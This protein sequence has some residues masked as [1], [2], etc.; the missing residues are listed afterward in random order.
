VWHLYLV[1]VVIGV[2]SVFFDVAYQS[3]IPILVPDGEVGLA[4]SRLET[5]AQLATTGGP[6]LGGLLMKIISAPLVMLTD[7]VGYAVSLLFFLR[8]QDDETAS[9]ARDPRASSA[10]WSDIGEGLSYVWRQPA[11][12]RITACT[13][14]S[15]LCATVVA[16]VMP[17][18]VLRELALGPFTLGLVLTCGSAGGAVGAWLTPRLR[19]RL[20]ASQLVVGANVL[21]ILFYLSNPLAAILGPDHPLLATC[22]LC[23]GQSGTMAAML[24]YNITQV[25]LRQILC[26]RPLLGRMNA[27]IRFIVGGVIPLSAMLSGWLAGHLGIATTMLLGGLGGLVAVVPV[28]RLGRH[29]PKEFNATTR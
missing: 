20:T 23:V 25:S 18:L 12:R 22:V 4:N 29:I 24:G 19:R 5:T 1:A 7:A 2:A 3:Y 17:L 13:G 8:V 26:P 15:N 14:I 28:L 16:T 10:L 11:I 21:A 27:S 9:R 6:A